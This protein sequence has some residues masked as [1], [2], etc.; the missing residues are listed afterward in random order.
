MR[1][2]AGDDIDVARG[3][4]LDELS[5]LQLRQPADLVAQ[6]CGALELQHRRGFFH[7][8]LQALDHFA[9]LAL[10]E[11]R[12]IVDVFLVVL[13]GDQPDARAGTALNLIEHARTGAIGENAVLAGAQLEY[14]L[15]QGHAF[16]YRARAREWPKIAVRLV[17]LA[18]MKA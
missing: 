11:Q 10:Q 1:G 17:E 4:A 2:D 9:G 7:L 8:P 12:R 15:Q 16:A 5:R 14:L 18:A 13:S 3:R 6:A